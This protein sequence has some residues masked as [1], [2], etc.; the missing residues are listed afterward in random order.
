MVIPERKNPSIQLIGVQPT[1]EIMHSPSVLRRLRY[2]EWF[3]VAR[4]ARR[5]IH[6][7]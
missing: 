3:C 6:W 7:R 2:N 4:S 5:V 1:F